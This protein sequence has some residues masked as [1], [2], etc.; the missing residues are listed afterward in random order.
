MAAPD[1]DLRPAPNR[2]EVALSR[3]AATDSAMQSLAGPLA[4][5]VGDGEL[6]AESADVLRSA[7]RALLTV[8]HGAPGSEL[9]VS[10]GP[11]HRWGVRVSHER[12]GLHVDLEDLGHAA[13][14]T[15][16]LVVESVSVAR[17][18][19]VVTAGPVQPAEGSAI[20]APREAVAA[21]LA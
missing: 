9:R 19:P 17:G 14:H 1:S 5:L 11:E 21:E 15:G 20:P 16:P 4:D 13:P 12:S 3:V 7:A 2:R 8:A 10:A 18:E 6:A